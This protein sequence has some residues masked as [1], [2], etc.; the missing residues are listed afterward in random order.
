MS[1]EYIFDPEE[2]NKTLQKYP[3]LKKVVSDPNNEGDSSQSFP[4]C[5]KTRKEIYRILINQHYQ[6]LEKLTKVLEIC[7]AN[8]WGNHKIFRTSSF[9]EL[10]SAISEILLAAWFLRKKFQVEFLDLQK[11][12]GPVADLEVKFENI[13]AKVEVYSPIDWAGMDDFY[14]DLRLGILHIDLPF[15]FD[16]KIRGKLLKCLNNGCLQYFDPWAFSAA[17]DEPAKRWSI[18]KPLLEKIELKLSKK[19]CKKRFVITSQKKALNSSVSITIKNI[20]KNISGIPERL[21]SILRPGLSGYRP[22]GMFDGL[23]SGKL[24]EKIK[25]GQLGANKSEIKILAVSISDLDYGN[26]EFKHEYYLPKFGESLINHIKIPSVDIIIFFRIYQKSGKL[27]LEIPLFYKK[28]D[29]GIKTFKKIF[30]TNQ[31][32]KSLSVVYLED[33]D[34]DANEKAEKLEQKRQIKEMLDWHARK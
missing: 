34:F 11:G 20:S 6:H 7:A 16:F 29:I 19:N 27:H 10:N 31:K 4:N 24:Q 33:L 3:F 14:N 30:E 5:R 18:I 32:Y 1:I 17:F 26:S 15:D 23:V 28:V 22:E 12:Q 8:G 13:S 2:I 21:G 9:S 25:K